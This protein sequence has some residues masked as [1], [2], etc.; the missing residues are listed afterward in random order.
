[1]LLLHDKAFNL[2]KVPHNHVSVKIVL[3][4]VQKFFGGIMAFAELT[5]K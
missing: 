5:G 3:Q 4:Q 2:E 1:M